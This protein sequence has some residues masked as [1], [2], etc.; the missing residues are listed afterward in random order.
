MKTDEEIVESK[1]FKNIWKYTRKHVA[2]YWPKDR[3]IDMIRKTNESNAKNKTKTKVEKV[4]DSYE[5]KKKT[6][7]HGLKVTNLVYVA[8]AI[9]FIISFFVKGY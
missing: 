3:I 8:F 9:L 1:R 5:R 4:F 7:S 6:K 2:K